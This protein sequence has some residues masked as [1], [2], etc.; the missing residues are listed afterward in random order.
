MQSRLSAL[1]PQLPDSFSTYVRRCFT[2]DTRSLA[3]FRILA[4]LLII[5]DVISRSRN[6]WFYYT[7]DGVVTQEVAELYTRSDAVSVFF[8]TNDPTIIAG[9]FALH[10]IVAV[11]LIAG[12][13]TRLALAISF[14]FVISLDHHNPFVT[15][16]ADTLFRMLLFWALFLPLG[17]RWS[18][19]AIHRDRSPR[20]AVANLATAAIML[21]MVFMYSVN[22]QNKFPSD[23]WHSGE[24]AILV[25]GIDE[26]TFFLGNTMREF[27]LFLQI[28]GFT[29][30]WLL[31]L[32][33][34]LILLYG[35]ARYP[36]IFLL[37]GGH[38]SF[39]ITVR[40][41]AFPYV[42]IMGLLV[43]L[44][45]AFWRDAG[46]IAERVGA[47]GL[48]AHVA[49]RA[50]RT[51]T[52][53]ATYL[54]GRLFEHRDRDL[55]V[56][57]TLTVL[58]AIGIVGLFILP[59]GAM[60][61]EGPYVA[62][63]PLPDDNP[64]GDTAANWN[65]DQPVWSIF[66]GPGPRNVDRYY[67]IAAETSDGEVIDIYN[68]GREMSWDRPDYELHHQHET[69]R[70][71]FYMNTIRRAGTGSPTQLYT[72]HLCEEWRTEHDTEIEQLEIWEMTE[73][74]T[75][76][77]IDAPEERERYADLVGRLSCGDGL[78]VA[79]QDPPPYDSRH[80]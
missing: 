69:Y 38:A 33:P 41:G 18:I 76:D 67:V 21:Q 25:M 29:W 3:L 74:I 55:F 71:R 43:F 66:A 53:L 80:D 13:K 62:E 57:R 50:R 77:T 27:P 24:A 59:T 8:H 47:A 36:H 45:P 75:L 15:S 7:D 5:A 6:F 39:A 30:L 2:I 10:V 1:S 64:I 14:L 46:L 20:S 23:L 61:E 78:P 49:S 72:E 22:G 63:N 54:P 68:D 79:F 19:D 52:L 9:L 70:Q 37:M 51:G 48:L 32:S 40:I 4:G 26:M 34:L 17:E 16:Y 65:V 12:Y 35:R 44:Q 31:L 73:R 60:L 56:R 11:V 28:G 58:V 42:A